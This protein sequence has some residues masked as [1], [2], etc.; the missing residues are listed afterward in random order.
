[1]IGLRFVS[2]AAGNEGGWRIGKITLGDRTLSDGSSLAGW[3]S[4]SE[5]APTPVHAW[6]VTLV[7]LGAKRAMRVPPKKF[8]LLKDYPKVVAVIAYDEPTEKIEQY[9]PYRLTVNG[10][11]QQGGSTP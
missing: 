9:A 6:H 10:V 1:M 5:F 11:V 3:K 4:P 7:G 2:D 8:A